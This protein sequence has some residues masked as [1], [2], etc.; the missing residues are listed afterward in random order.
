MS[1]GRYYIDPK[2]NTSFQIFSF[3]PMF[4]LKYEFKK[5]L[6]VQADT[7]LMFSTLRFKKGK[8]K[9]AFNQLELTLT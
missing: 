1:Y 5:P 2:Y 4:N 3:L 6:S 8:R 9:L 7:I